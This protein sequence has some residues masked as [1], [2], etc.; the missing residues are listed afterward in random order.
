MAQITRDKFLEL[1]KQAPGTTPEQLRDTLLQR[2]HNLE[3]YTPPDSLNVVKQQQQEGKRGIGG[4]LTGAVKGLASTVSNISSLGQKGLE[5]ITGIES[6]TP[7]MTSYL[8]DTIKPQGTAENIGFGTEQIG[9]FFIPGGAAAKAGKAVEALNIGSKAPKIV[10]GATK[11]LAK[12]GT[13]AVTS[14]G[15]IALQGG[16]KEDVQTAGLIGGLF[17]FAT[18]TLGVLGKGAKESAKYISSTLSGVPKSAIEQAFKNPVAVSNAIKT[19]VQEGGEETA[20]KIYNQ[21]LDA[22]GILKKARTSTYESNLQNLEKSL[23]KTKSG[24][25]YVKRALTEAEA[26]VT[27]GYKGGEIL[28]PTNLGTSGIKNVVTRTLKDFGGKA[29]GKTLDF[30]EMAIDKTHASKIQEVVNRIYG[31]KNVTPTGINK[32]TQVIDGYRLG[33]INLGSSEKQFNAIISRF[34]S[35]VSDYL[36]ERVPAVKKLRADYASQSKVIDNIINQ[37]KLNSKDPSTALRK[38]VNVFNPKSEVYRP[39]VQELGEKAGI[40]LM[41][42]IAGLTMSRWTPEGLGKYLTGMI[43]GAGGVAALVNPTALLAVPGSALTS[44][45][46]IIG[47]AVTTF[48]KASKNKAIPVIKKAASTITKAAVIK[49]SQ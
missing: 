12:A 21:T 14:A 49:S 10:Q 40:D 41:S 4:F 1:L 19:A 27:K 15:L 35:N 8:G 20:Q 45:P 36:G 34:K 9:E 43:Q 26:K 11:L 3:G 17:P 2:G 16:D 32:L 42:D 33:G 24:Q 46:R 47:K 39:V 5:K 7:D 29:K 31:W 37:L 22:L 6:G 44:S 30:S 13:E 18:K 28:V 48:G 25:L 38:L 23:S